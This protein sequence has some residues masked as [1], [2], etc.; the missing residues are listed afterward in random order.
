[1]Q[2]H[3]PKCK[4]WLYSVLHDHPT[5]LKNKVHP[6]NS[7]K[8]FPFLKKKKKKKKKP[9]TKKKTKKRKRKWKKKFSLLFIILAYFLESEILDKRFMWIKSLM[10]H[11]KMF[12][13]TP[14][15]C[16]SMC[17]PKIIGREFFEQLSPKRITTF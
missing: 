13:W 9:W 5:S 4:A 16:F 7:N 2:S 14:F 12:C 3:V 15:H 8:H 6:F 11:N 10:K 1:M 17:S